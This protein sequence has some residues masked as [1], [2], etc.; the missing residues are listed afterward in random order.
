MR[1]EIA[2][3]IWTLPRTVA[4]LFVACQYFD[5]AVGYSLFGC[6]M[7]MP[8]FQHVVSFATIPYIFVRLH[9][10]LID[11]TSPRRLWLYT[12]YPLRCKTLAISWIEESYSTNEDDEIVPMSVAEWFRKCKYAISWNSKGCRQLYVRE[13]R[14][15]F[16]LMCSNG[17]VI[18]RWSLLSLGSYQAGASLRPIVDSL[19]L[20]VAPAPRDMIILKLFGA[21]PKSRLKPHTRKEIHFYC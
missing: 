21:R 3:S 20:G 4:C 19:P 10:S 13:D 5:N 8:L 17:L 1:I 12:P 7:C 9:W 15:A 11:F 6:A 14:R 2:G 16:K 18:K